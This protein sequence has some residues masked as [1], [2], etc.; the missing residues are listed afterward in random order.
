MSVTP[1]GSVTIRVGSSIDTIFGGTSL[2]SC[3][4]GAQSAMGS[5]GG[6]AIM[7]VGDATY[8]GGKQLILAEYGT[9]FHPTS[10]GLN[11]GDD[12]YY[13]EKII[14][15]AN[16]YAYAHVYFDRLDSFGFNVKLSYSSNVLGYDSGVAS[17]N[18]PNASAKIISLLA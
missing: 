6:L 12:E 4:C 11:C 5:M 14:E 2:M 15:F 10:N 9:G 7:G 8:G 1:G 16:T 3:I 18:K 17:N 13:I